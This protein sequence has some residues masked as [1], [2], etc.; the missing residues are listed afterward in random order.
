MKLGGLAGGDS[1]LGVDLPDKYPVVGRDADF[2]A[3][4]VAI[5]CFSV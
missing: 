4:G 1:S 3:D 5:R 2:R